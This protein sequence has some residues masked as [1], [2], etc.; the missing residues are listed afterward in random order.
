M[1]KVGIVGCGGIGMT[2]AR[3]WKS[4]EGVQVSA[5]VDMN[6]EK[7]AA[8]AEACKCPYYLCADELPEDLDAVSV[9]TPPATHFAIAKQ[10]LERGFHV[11]CEKPLTMDVAEGELL[12][13]LAKRQKKELGVGFKMRFESVF[14]EAKKY[15]PEIGTLR[16]LVTTKQQAF[17]PR[18]EGA[19]VKKVGAMYEL[20]IHDFDLISFISGIY[21]EKVLGATLRHARGWE[22]ED[23]F[24]A[25]VEYQQGV[26][27]TLQGMY[28]EKTT[29]C[30]RDLTLTFLG[31]NGYMRVERP[32]R[33]I[34]HTHEFRVIEVPPA[35]TSSFAL[36]LEHF[37]QAVSGK[38]ENTLRASDAV[39]M[40]WLIEEI[41]KVAS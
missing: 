40:T 30:F 20:S 32:D 14:V 4:L 26:T 10:L 2:H 36:E 23:A 9:V 24:A 7:A 12:D 3:T 29:F 19:W 34:L 41:R 15:L 5:V 18:P 17:N 13:A 27:A 1:F 37:R 16:S 11:F 25:L 33:I 31:E 22:K 21:P 35:K 39:R 38:V 8:A 6:Q 28:C